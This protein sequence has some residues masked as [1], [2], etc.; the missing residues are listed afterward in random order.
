MDFTVLNVLNHSPKDFKSLEIR[1]ILAA[2]G[3]RAG[4]AAETVVLPPRLTHGATKRDVDGAVDLPAEE[5]AQV[6]KAWK[7]W[8]WLFLKQIMDYR[9]DWMNDTKGSLMMVA[10]M[11][12]TITFQAA[13][14]HPGGVWQNDTTNSRNSAR[15][16]SRACV[17]GNAVLAYYYSDEYLT[18]MRWNMIS[19]FGSL[20]VLFLVISGFP[21]SNK[22]CLWLLSLV[23]CATVTCLAYTFFEAMWLVVPD[24]LICQYE[25][26][27]ND[28]HRVWAVMYIV[29]LLLFIR[30]CYWLRSFKYKAAWRRLLRLGPSTSKLIVDSYTH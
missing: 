3:A 16:N 25:R 27:T 9:G 18:F 17:A 5:Q 2:A 30:M 13:I 28:V 7:T 12:A 21:L 4:A 15:N 24:H 8:V 19:F 20:M 23:M 6:P 29:G 26:L 11:I 22:F 10:T 1:E 14:A